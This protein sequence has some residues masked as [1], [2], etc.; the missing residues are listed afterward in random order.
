MSVG[1]VRERVGEGAEKHSRHMR[2]RRRRTDRVAG[3]GM[4]F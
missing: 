3:G 2:R 4:F 1:R